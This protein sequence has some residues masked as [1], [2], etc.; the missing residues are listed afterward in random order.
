VNSWHTNTL[1]DHVHCNLLFSEYEHTGHDFQ[2]LT[3]KLII[4]VDLLNAFERMGIAGRYI[5][6]V[7]GLWSFISEGFMDQLV[8][9]T[10]LNN[11][12]NATKVTINHFSFDENRLSGGFRPISWAFE[13]FS[14]VVGSLGILSLGSP[15]CI[16]NGRCCDRRPSRES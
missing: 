14:S 11:P 13:L 9:R 6:A 7:K 3:V 5:F 2:R 16:V 1:K 8:L 12:T 15:R 10:H 4:P